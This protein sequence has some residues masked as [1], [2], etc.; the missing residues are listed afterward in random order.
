MNS[1]LVGAG[2]SFEPV[3]A[4]GPRSYSAKNAV[5]LLEDRGLADATVVEGE[6]H[7]WP[8][9]KIE[10][11]AADLYDFLSQQ[12]ES[13]TKD[14]PASASPF[15]YLASASLR[16]D[17]GCSRPECRSEKLGVLARYAA[18]YAD[19]VFLP[20]ALRRPT[21]G[22]QP[23]RL[24]DEVSKTAF[25]VLELRPLVEAGIIRPILPHMH[26]CSD[27]AKREFE[28][29]GA[30]MAA[31]RTQAKRHLDE[32]KFTCMQVLDSPKIVAVEMD[33]PADYLEHGSMIRVYQRP[34][35]WFPRTLKANAR[36]RVPKATVRRAGLVEQIFAGIAADVY[37]HQGFQ[38]RFD[39]GYLTDLPGE[40]EFLRTL[41][42]KDELAIRTAQVCSQLA[43]DIPLLTDLPVRAV[44]EIRNESRESFELYRST[45]GTLINEYVGKHR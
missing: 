18:M 16:A 9:A 27:C 43:H 1:K 22:A 25:S 38:D 17:S 3:P 33:G 24:R 13:W 31:A 6:L 26:Y 11:L 28:R 29:F 8:I 12:R 37:F 39:A 21:A 34:P 2:F 7:K 19:H 36:Y 14:D 15:N 4:L 10:A 41:S 20:V 32:F 42:V 35:E 23:G 30:G 45:L 5:E 44:I 40:A